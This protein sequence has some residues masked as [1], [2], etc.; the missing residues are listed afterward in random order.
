[1]CDYKCLFKSIHNHGKVCANNISQER[2]WVDDKGPTYPLNYLFLNP[3]PGFS[4]LGQM[5]F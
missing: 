2:D 3:W 1:M 5:E 4:E